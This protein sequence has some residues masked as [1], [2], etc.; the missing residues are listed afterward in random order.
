MHSFANGVDLAIYD[1]GAA[2]NKFWGRNRNGAGAGIFLPN[3]NALELL[4]AGDST[5]NLSI[6]GNYMLRGS[7]APSSGDL[8]TITLDDRI[9][10]FTQNDDGEDVILLYNVVNE[11]LTSSENTN[12]LVVTDAF[13]GGTDLISAVIGPMMQSSQQLPMTQPQLSA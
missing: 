10:S 9:G 2:H 8:S 7:W 6:F 13:K 3:D 5:N 1:V 4:D 12:Y 11:D